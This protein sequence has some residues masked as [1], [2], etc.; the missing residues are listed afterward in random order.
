MLVRRCEH[1]R[2]PLE[3]AGH[4]CGHRCAARAR[5]AHRARHNTPASAH[6]TLCSFHN[7]VNIA[8]EHR[9]ARCH[10]NRLTSYMV[11]DKD[12]FGGIALD[13]SR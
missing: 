11:C 5:H 12:Q 3:F 7:Q 13:Y 9:L 10:R 1:Q 6:I 2:R 8:C 4:H